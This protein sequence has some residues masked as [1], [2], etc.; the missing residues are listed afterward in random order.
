VGEFEVAARV[1]ASMSS[2]PLFRQKS[3]NGASTKPSITFLFGEQ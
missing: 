1:S 2:V 3:I